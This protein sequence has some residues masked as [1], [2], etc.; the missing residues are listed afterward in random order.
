MTGLLRSPRDKDFS[1]KMLGKMNFTYPTNQ[2]C[3]W[4]IKAKDGYKIFLN[5]TH[6]DIEGQKVS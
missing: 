1:N 5:I 2:N 3:K 4:L 6:L